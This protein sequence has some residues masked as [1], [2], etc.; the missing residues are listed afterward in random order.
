LHY[1]AEGGIQEFRVTAGD[2]DGD[3]IASLTAA[4]L[5]PGATFAPN[6]PPPTIS[7]STPPPEGCRK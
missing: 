4:P 5:P 6:L 3:P 7:I 1:A 2:P